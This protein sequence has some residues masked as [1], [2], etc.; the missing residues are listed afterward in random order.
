MNIE[1][2]PYQYDF[3]YARERHPAFVGGWGVG[4]SL[5]GIA[6]AR[7]YSKLIPDNLGVIFRKTA[8]SLF[9]STLRDFERYSNVKVD[10]QRNLKDPNGSITMFRHID[11]IG[12][13]N[14]QNLNLGWFMIEQGDEL[15]TDKEFFMLWG[16]LR[17]ELKPTPEFLKLELALRSGWVIAN[18]GDHWMKPLWKDGGLE[19]ARL[20]EANT[21][22]NEKNLPADF[23]ESLRVLEKTKPEVYRQFVMNDWNITADRHVMFTRDQLDAL[24][25]VTHDHLVTRKVISIDPSE[26]GDACVIMVIE[27]YTIIDKVKLHVN[28]TMK[29]VGEA[30]ILGTRHNCNFFAGDAIGTGKGVFDRLAEMGKKVLAIKSSESSSDPDAHFNL[31]SEMICYLQN[32]ILRR[33]LPPIEDKDV[34][35]QMLAVRYDPKAVNSKGRMKIVPKDETK[36]LLGQSPDDFDAYVYG[37]WALK[38]AEA[39]STTP[40]RLKQPVFSGAGGW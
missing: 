25:L 19:G 5:T 11:E 1:L 17:R 2:R 20:V 27:N 10:S 4:K 15:D 22:D 34:I 30:L 31:R 14:Q 35:K 39:E 38:D 33:E 8:K 37:I 7:I 36:K 40:L 29:I 28:D 26:G 23:I 16:R 12:D 13:I 6:R 21:F 3:I 9:D 18:A 32:L 24:R